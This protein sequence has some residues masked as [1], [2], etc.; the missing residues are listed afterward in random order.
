MSEDRSSNI[1]WFLAG[2][3]LGALVGILYAPKSG[4]ETREA[5]GEGFDEGKDYLTARGRE[6]RE[7]ASEWAEKGKDRAAD[8]VDRGKETVGRHKESIAT[9]IEAGRE[10]YRDATKK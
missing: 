9:A 6:V 4:R 7:R 2:L 1:G 8:W 10:A 5:I 3:G